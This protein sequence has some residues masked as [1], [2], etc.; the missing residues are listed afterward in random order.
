MDGRSSQRSNRKA[1][2]HLWVPLLWV[3]LIV[4]FPGESCSTKTHQRIAVQGL[5]LTLS[6]L[7]EMFLRFSDRGITSN[8]QE[9]P[10]PAPKACDFWSI[11]CINDARDSVVPVQSYL[12]FSP[13]ASEVAISGRASPWRGDSASF[14]DEGERLH[15]VQ[16]LR[17]TVWVRVCRAAVRKV[18]CAPRTC[19]VGVIQLL[20]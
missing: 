5:R 2:R 17:G 1:Q 9:S 8:T 7:V 14:W 12:G 19:P 10:V 18:I 4:Q 20:V 3:T 16:S 15:P 6:R 11:P 13:H